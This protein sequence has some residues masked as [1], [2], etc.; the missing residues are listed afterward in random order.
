MEESKF[1]LAFFHNIAFQILS[2]F[3]VKRGFLPRSKIEEMELHLHIL[4]RENIGISWIVLDGT[5]QSSRRRYSRRRKRLILKEVQTCRDA[6]C[7]TRDPILYRCRSYALFRSERKISRYLLKVLFF[8]H[9]SWIV[10]V[11]HKF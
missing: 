3:P 9:T 1:L 2:I 11:V 6:K 7:L 8:F 10:F 4:S 5:F